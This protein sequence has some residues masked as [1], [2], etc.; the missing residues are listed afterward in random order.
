MA[1]A[2]IRP[3]AD[4]TNEWTSPADPGNHHN[5]IDDV[6]VVPNAGDGAFIG[7][8]K[9][10]DGDIEVFDM[11]ND[12]QD[13]DGNSI[14]TIVIYVRAREQGG[15]TT[16]IIVNVNLGGWLANRYLNPTLSWEWYPLAWGSLNCDQTDLDNLQ[17][18]FTAGT[19]VDP[20]FQEIDVAYCVITYDQVAVG[21]GHDFLGIPAANID[22][23][24]G[25]PAA[26][27]DNIMGL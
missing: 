8:N 21:Y 4:V 24:M 6:V 5:Y 25:I 12:T 13:V 10:D 16:N 1:T 27:I 15:T 26:N 19:I 3:T 20:Q 14:S 7:A 22:S 11:D 17:I 9:D 23:I 2:I 18:K